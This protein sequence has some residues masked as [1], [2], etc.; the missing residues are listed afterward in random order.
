[1]FQTI[2]GVF[3][4]LG[5]E[6]ITNYNVDG[7]SEPPLMEACGSLKQTTGHLP[8]KTLTI[9]GHLG[10]NPCICWFKLNPLHDCIF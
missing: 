3:W 9:S 4:W 7:A 1:M 6:I 2:H 8:R 5:D 10:P